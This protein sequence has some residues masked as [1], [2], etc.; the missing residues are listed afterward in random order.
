[1]AW[2][3]IYR[4]VTRSAWTRIVLYADIELENFS[5]TVQELT[6][7]GQPITISYKDENEQKIAPLRP[8]EAKI[9]FVSAS[10]ELEWIIADDDRKYRVT[11]RDDSH[12]HWRGVLS[13]DDCSEAYISGNRI[14]T[15]TASDGLALLKEEY[16]RRITD[17]TVYGKITPLEAV[18]DCLYRTYTE[19]PIHVSCNV[20]EST[21]IAAEEKNP[22]DQCLLHTKLLYLTDSGPQ[23][24]YEVLEVI[25]QAFE[26]TLFQQFG[27]WHIVRKLDDLSHKPIYSSLYTMPDLVATTIS[28]DFEVA[29][30]ADFIPINAGH[31]LSFLKPAQSSKVQHDYVI[32]DTPENEKMTDGALISATSTE[33]KYYIDFWTYQYGSVTTPS[34]TMPG[35]AYRKE[36]LDVN[37]NLAESYIVVPDQGTNDERLRPTHGVWVDKGDRLSLSAET[38]LSADLGGAGTGIVLRVVLYGDS[39]QK[40]T[41]DATSEVWQPTLASAIGASAYTRT[42]AGGDDLREWT[43][44]YLH[45][46]EAGQEVEYTKPFPEGGILEMW[47]CDWSTGGL[48]SWYRNINI[49]VLLFQN[50]ITANFKGEFSTTSTPIVSR[51]NAEVNIQ[52]GDAPKRLIASALWRLTNENELTNGWGRYNE[53]RTERLININSQDLQRSAARVFKK[54]DGDFK[55]IFYDG[56]KLLGPGNTFIIDNLEWIATN[57]ELDLHNETFTATLQEFRDPVKDTPELSTEFKYL[58][59]ERS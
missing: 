37:G 5:G 42:Y 44:F 41:W 38:R 46:T 28:Q 56:G 26:C 53:L 40:Y 33:R 7:S 4:V 48:E 49:D 47:F 12:V 43:S 1:M 9:Q 13:T 17:V 22:L 39:G 6:G 31:L 57:I 19:L 16:W 15:L 11:I 2:N 55:G 8:S 59:N 18:R 21:M 35:T 14:F 51:K 25:M 3:T 34:N 50:Q 45:C 52:L 58:F 20:Y 24:M 29:R 27:E 54:L 32:P 36:A 23:N 30:P 10:F